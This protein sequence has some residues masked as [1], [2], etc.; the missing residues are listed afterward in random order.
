M[1]LFLLQAM[2]GGDESTED[3]GVAGETRAAML[4]FLD[5]RGDS[6]GE[7]GNAVTVTE[8]LREKEDEAG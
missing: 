2:G 4:D 7:T 1:P 6:D 8:E 5:E 3:V